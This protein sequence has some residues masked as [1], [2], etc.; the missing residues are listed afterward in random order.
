MWDRKRMTNLSQLN[1]R[2]KQIGSQ[3]KRRVR[4][5][6]RSRPKHWFNTEFAHFVDEYDKVMTENFAQGFVVHRNVVLA[7]Q[8]VSELAFHHGECGF[9]VT[10]LV[11]VLQE[12]IAPELKVVIHLFPCSAA[13]PTVMGRKSK[14]RHGSHAGNR[15]HVH[16][17]CVALIC[18]DLR[19]LKVLRGAANQS[20]KHGRIVSVPTVNL[21]S[22]N[23]VRLGSDHQ[24]T[25]DP[26]MLLPNL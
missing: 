24:V 7:P 12:L 6:N 9:N 22:R 19:D 20:R 25:L 1:S 11:V 8:A 13:V 16:S 23:D 15:F 21:D 17:A 18:R 4:F 26:I 2:G 14:I 3:E 10:A 5:L